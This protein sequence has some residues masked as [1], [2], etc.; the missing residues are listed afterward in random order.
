MYV[1]ITNLDDNGAGFCQEI[2]GDCQAITQIGQIAMDA[3]APGVS[4]SFH[5]LGL[6]G[7][8]VYAAIFYISTSSLLKKLMFV[9]LFGFQRGVAEMSRL[10]S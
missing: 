9:Y 1:F 10:F 7:D 3:I 2:S 8:V 6:A 5:L 4:E